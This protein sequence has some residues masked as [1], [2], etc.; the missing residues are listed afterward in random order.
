MGSG[1]EKRIKEAIQARE[2]S[3]RLFFLFEIRY[4]VNIKRE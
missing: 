3:D 1:T 4:N 2:G